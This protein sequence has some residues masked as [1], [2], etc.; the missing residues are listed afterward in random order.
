MWTLS[1]LGAPPPSNNAP[2]LVSANPQFVD[3]LANQTNDVIFRFSYDE[4]PWVEGEARVRIGIDV[5]VPACGNGVLD[6]GEECEP[7]KAAPPAGTPL[8]PRSCDDLCTGGGAPCRDD[9]ECSSA[10]CDTSECGVCDDDA[11]AC[12]KACDTLGGTA[13][14]DASGSS[15]GPLSAQL[16]QAML[17]G[18][19]ACNAECKACSSS[20]AEC[21]QNCADHP[22]VDA[23]RATGFGCGACSKQINACK[24]ACAATSSQCTTACKAD[25]ER[26]RSETCHAACATRQNNCAASCGACQPCRL[27]QSCPNH[28]ALQ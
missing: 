16:L 25:C 14:S 11:G 19:T 12:H 3:A 2:T 28:P 7:D 15:L 24:D 9:S 5:D 6:P 21:Q 27:T 26:K 20:E 8:G 1:T 4:D 13:P 22:C 17:S 10:V 18:L 23:C